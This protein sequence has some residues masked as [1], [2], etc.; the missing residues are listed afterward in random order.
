M[1]CER[2][3]KTTRCG[4]TLG[5]QVQNAGR[6]RAALTAVNPG[7]GGLILLREA[8]RRLGLIKSVAHR[9]SDQRQKRKVRHLAMT[10][11]RQR[12]MALY[13]GREDLND[14]EKLAERSGSPTGVGGGHARQHADFVL[15]R[16]RAGPGERMGRERGVNRAVHPLEERGARELGPR[17]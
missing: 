8:D 4:K 9:L 5:S 3:I 1:W 7:A 15:L 16:E 6:W 11:L 17:L 12:M 2:S 14:A 13:A 10:L